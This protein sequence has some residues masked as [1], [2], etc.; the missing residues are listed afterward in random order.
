MESR[1]VLTRK[2]LEDLRWRYKTGKDE[3]ELFMWQVMKHDAQWVYVVLWR[4]RNGLIDIRDWTDQTISGPKPLVWI[5]MADHFLELSKSNQFKFYM[6]TKL[7]EEEI[8]RVAH[9]NNRAFCASIGDHSQLSWEEAPEWQKSSSIK[10]VR[11]LMEHPD[12]KPSESHESWLQQK[13]DEGWKHGPVKNP[14]TKE[15]PDFLP[16]DELPVT[17]KSKD[18]IFQAVVRTLLSI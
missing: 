5:G 11:H 1:R 3:S 7:T 8:A 17:S 6:S 9:E 12:A 18:Y 10:G 16:Y 13:K 14:E 15:H 4:K 2:E